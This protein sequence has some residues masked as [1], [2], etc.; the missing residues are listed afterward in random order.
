M[1]FSWTLP[2]RPCR[3]LCFAMFNQDIVV[4][5]QSTKWK[6]I[7]QGAPAAPGVKWII[8]DQIHTDRK[9]ERGKTPDR[10][11]SNFF[12][13]LFLSLI[14][15]SQLITITVWLYCDIIIINA[16]IN[17]SFL[18]CESLNRQPMHQSICYLSR[19]LTPSHG[20]FG[21]GSGKGGGEIKARN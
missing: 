21:L 12:L 14:A 6:T 17:Y 20:T 4:V 8:N 13:F 11:D 19:F 2:D 5:S 10:L 18:V 9:R 15:G 3:V 16:N 1:E 7:R